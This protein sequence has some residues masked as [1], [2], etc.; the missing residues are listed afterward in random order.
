LPQERKTPEHRRDGRRRFLDS[1]T[2]ELTK[3]DHLIDRAKKYVRESGLREL[4]QKEVE[5]MRAR[6][7]KRSE[8]FEREIVKPLD[9]DLKRREHEKR[10]RF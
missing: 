8:R 9:S 1:L 5:T 4:T 6:A 2:D 7:S 3:L 10:K